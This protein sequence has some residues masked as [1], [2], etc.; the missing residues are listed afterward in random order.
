[1]RRLLFAE[2]LC[3]PH[4]LGRDLQIDAKSSRSDVSH[5]WGARQPK[6]R[7]AHVPIRDIVNGAV[8]SWRVD[9][10]PRRKALPLK[11]RNSLAS[12]AYLAPP[13]RHPF[14]GGADSPHLGTLNPVP[15]LYRESRFAFSNALHRSSPYTKSLRQFLHGHKSLKI[16]PRR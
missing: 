14:P 2:T 6:C 7:R 8:C 11:L 15:L 16:S 3:L 4:F 1:M 13:S 12:L 5:R 10:F 9:I